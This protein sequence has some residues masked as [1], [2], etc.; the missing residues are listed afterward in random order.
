MW[1]GLS[2]HNNKRTKRS[3]S[4]RKIC[5][6]WV[7]WTK[8]GK[9]TAGEGVT[10]GLLSWI[11]GE[12]PGYSRWRSTLAANGLLSRINRERPG[13]NRWGSRLVTNRL[14]SQINDQQREARLQQMSNRQHERI[15]A[16]TIK[17]RQVQLHRFSER[18]QQSHDSE[19]TNT[20]F[21]TAL[22]SGMHS[23]CVEL[24]HTYSLS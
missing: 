17:E 1:C 22:T 9:T 19:W 10:N 2:S 23:I 12:R 5:Q 16:K 13:Y 11:N 24:Y 21:W 4:T 18:G 20:T 14:L 6:C 7:C 15:A 3:A 8:R